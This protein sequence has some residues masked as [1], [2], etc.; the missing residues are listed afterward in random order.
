MFDKSKELKL[1]NWVL[2]RY[3]PTNGLYYFYN[4]KKDSC[5]KCEDYIG[6]IIE[7][8]DGSLSFDEIIAI[9]LNSNSEEDLLEIKSSLELFVDFL[10][11]EEYLVY[12]CY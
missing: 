8:F 6:N 10:I 11:E 1:A 5:W 12:S 4:A 7:T 2:K 9:L 3:E